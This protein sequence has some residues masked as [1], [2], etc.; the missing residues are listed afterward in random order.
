VIV[1]GG[2]IS[3]TGVPRA[4]TTF[5]FDGEEYDAADVGTLAGRLAFPRVRPYAG[6]G[7]GTPANAGR[8]VRLVTDLGV[9][10]GRPTFTLRASGAAGDGELAA[11][12]AAQQASTQR[13]VDRY[14]KLY[15]VLSTGLSFR[16]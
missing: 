6:I 1:G 9:A 13:D 5:E 7:W 11:D 10:L 14:L 8:S 16:F 12:V 3:G 4:G 2:D 15:P